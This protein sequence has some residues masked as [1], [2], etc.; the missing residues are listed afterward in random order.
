MNS[1]LLYNTFDV[2]FGGLSK[3]LQLNKQNGAQSESKQTRLFK[4][5]VFKKQTNSHRILELVHIFHFL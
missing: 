1:R 2:Y 3:Q 5:N 4:S